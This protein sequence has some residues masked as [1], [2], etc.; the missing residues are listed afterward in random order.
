MR[1]AVALHA[2]DTTTL[3][4]QAHSGALFEE[5]SSDCTDDSRFEIAISGW[6]NYTSLVISNQQFD[7]STIVLA[8]PDV[9][10]QAIG[11]AGSGG[12]SAAAWS[13]PTATLLVLALAALLLG[14]R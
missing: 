10:M 13:R 5:L 14:L 8:C 11:A 6:L 3:A 9:M 2:I 12:T 4:G 1:V 7:S